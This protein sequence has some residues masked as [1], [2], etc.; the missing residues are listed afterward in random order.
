MCK[1]KALKYKPWHNIK[2]LWAFTNSIMY[3]SIRFSGDEKHENS[4]QVWV[5]E[6]VDRILQ[7]RVAAQTVSGCCLW[8]GSEYIKVEKYEVEELI[9]SM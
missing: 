1:M 9:L 3:R 2:L 8:K 7:L 5:L 4:L 6:I